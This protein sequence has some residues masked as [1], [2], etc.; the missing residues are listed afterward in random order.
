MRRLFL[1]VALA[2][3]CGAG[4]EPSFLGTFP[5]Q[6]ATGTRT[7]SDTLVIG[8]SGTRLTLTFAVGIFGDPSS[9]TPKTLYGSATGLAL[10]LPTQAA[11]VDQGTGL[12]TGALSGSGTLTAPGTLQLSLSFQTM[13]GTPSQYT[14]SGTR[15]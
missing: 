9:A 5:V 11:Q 3:A 1:L 7:D 12:Q 2:S 6:V 14:V 4:A 13:G 15:Q 10:T 8:E